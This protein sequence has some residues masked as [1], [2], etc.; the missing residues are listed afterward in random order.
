MSS[1]IPPDPITT[2]YN[3]SAWAIPELTEEEMIALDKAYI[4]FPIAQNQPITFPSTV[5]GQTAANTENS[6]IVATT[7]FV[8]NFFTYIRTLDWSWSGFQSF[9]GGIN[10][11]SIGPS[12]VGG[13]LSIANFVSGNV[14]IATHASR[15]AVLHLGDGNTA[16]GGIHIGNGASAT[17]N[18]NILNGTGSTG[19]INLG[20][21]TSTT[22]V[23]CPLTPNY[24]YPVT[25]TKIGYINSVTVATLAVVVSTDQQLTSLSIGAGTWILQG[26]AGLSVGTA[27]AMTLGFNTSVSLTAA[28]GINTLQL[29]N[30]L[31]PSNSTCIMISQNATTTYYLIGRTA[32]AGNW[33]S[34]NFFA[35]RIA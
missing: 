16:S 27:S 32:Q 30:T 35:T 21:A 33:T 26:D 20:S 22:N 17:N 23:N 19:T 5:S 28:R 11:S 31:V 14:N 10:A 4:K 18:V 13:T 34:I 9:T 1:Q 2:N 24:T 7:A 25:S 15:G 29:N 3:P 8:N 12:T 6:A